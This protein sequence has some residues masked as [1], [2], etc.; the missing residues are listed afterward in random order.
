M[1]SIIAAMSR[2]RV[3]GS[4][5][6]IPWDI[7]AD[8]KFFR[9]TTTGHTLIMGRKTFESIGRPLPE[10]KCIIMTRQPAYEAPGCE[11]AGSLSE[12][13][14]LC[15]EQEEI[16]VAGGSEI[17]RQALPLAGRIYLSVIDRDVAGDAL[18]PAIPEGEFT[19]LRR[20]RLSQKPPCEV[21]VY[22]RAQ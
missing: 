13:L 11:T 3:I 17:Y 1:L 18:F 15:G 9:E 2:N 6:N 8:R 20:E 19:E 14:A 22:E 5:E 4:K 12:A 16:F 21:I 7:S 10:R